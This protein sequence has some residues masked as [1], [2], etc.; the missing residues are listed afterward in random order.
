M[1]RAA[2]ILSLLATR[3]ADATYTASP[4]DAIT[5]PECDVNTTVSLRYSSSSKRLYLESA[6]GTAR[7]GCITLKQI[8]EEL[9]GK[10]PLYAVNSTSGN[11]C[12]FAT[13]TWLLTETLYVKDGITLQ[14][15]LRVTPDGGCACAWCANG[16]C[17]RGKHFSSLA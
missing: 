6:D 4:N 8:W 15:R 2:A 11:A 17:W 13:G 10:V 3:R 5:K 12:D 1:L 14:V 9:C 16:C 7:G